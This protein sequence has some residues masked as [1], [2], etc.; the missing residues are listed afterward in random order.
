[1]EKGLNTVEACEGIIAGEVRPSSA[2][3]A[4]SC[5]PS[6]TLTDGAGLE[7]ACGCRSSIDQAQ[8][9]PLV[10]GEITYI[11]PCLGRIEIDRQA[12]GPQAV[13]MEDSHGCIHGSR[14]QARPPARIC[15]PS[16]DRR[17]ASPRRR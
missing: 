3:A 13:S 7:P 14:G 2:W 4:I 17:R 5:A 8:P 12:S 16:R 11:L 10:H 15:C 9:Q 6:R 1:M